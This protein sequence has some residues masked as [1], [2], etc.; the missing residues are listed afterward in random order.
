MKTLTSNSIIKLILEILRI[1]ISDEM[2]I[3]KC[4]N[5]SDLTYTQKIAQEAIKR[6]EKQEEQGEKQEEKQGNKE[7]IMSGGS[8]ITFS[9]Y[10]KRKLRTR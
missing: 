3:R 5:D 8:Y 7:N 6:E 2:I 1:P 9:T 4:G 10:K